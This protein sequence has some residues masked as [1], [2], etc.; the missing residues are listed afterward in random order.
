VR[1][2][3]LN[4]ILLFLPVLTAGVAVWR[5]HA[6]RSELRVRWKRQIGFGLAGFLVFILLFLPLTVDYCGRGHSENHTAAALLSAATVFFGTRYG[7]RRIVS[8]I[9]IVILS[10]WSVSNYI[11]LVHSR[12]FIGTTDMSSFDNRGKT[13]KGCAAEVLWHSPITRIYR[14]HCSKEMKNGL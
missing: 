7:I 8:V 4:L 11:E 10:N 2:D 1:P 5:F 12:E 3:H 9:V 13:K 14:F 6:S